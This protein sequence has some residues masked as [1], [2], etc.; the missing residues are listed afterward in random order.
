MPELSVAKM[1]YVNH[2]TLVLVTL[3]GPGTA[4]FAR[5]KCAGSLGPQG[6]LEVGASTCLTLP[7]DPAIKGGCECHDHVNQRYDRVQRVAHLAAFGG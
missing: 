7:A 2:Y 3:L 5:E 4:A 1:D 6:K